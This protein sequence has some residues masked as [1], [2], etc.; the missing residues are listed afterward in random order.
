MSN[1]QG[2]IIA[3]NLNLCIH[4]VHL[5]RSDKSCYEQVAWLI[6]QVLRR[7]YLLHDTVFHNDDSCTKSHS[8]CL[9]M[10]YVNDGSAQ[11]LMQ[12]GDLNTHLNSQFCI[13]IGKRFVHQEYFRITDDGTSH[14]N[15]LS[16]TTG[17][18]VRLT[19]KKFVK[20]KNLGSFTNLLVNL[21]LWH[22]A[23]L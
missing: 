2:Y 23:E 21:I 20:V 12:F 19:V 11:V 4:E 18:S 9:V 16:L 15:T 6:I 7:I 5:R 10:G 22:L 14:G 8:F 1:F 13:Q 3:G 17:K